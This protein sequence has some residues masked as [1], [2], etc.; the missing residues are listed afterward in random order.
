VSN[1]LEYAVAGAVLA[2]LLLDCRLSIDATRKQLVV[3]HNTHPTGDPILNECFKTMKASKRR[4]SLQTWVSCL[5]GIKNLRDKVAQQLCKRRVL[6]ADEQKV[7]FIFTRRTYPEINPIPEKEIVERLHAAIFSE[8]DKL[9]SRTVVLISLAN[10]ADLLSKTFGRKELRSRKKRIE[11][12]VNGE[13]TGKATKEVITLC[14][15][16]LIVSA[17]VPAIITST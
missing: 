16:A 10:G 13:M 8:D 4:A 2:E 17:I 11:Q 9:E 14:Q 3:L 15:A 7:L 6:R 1:Y 5:A 12:I